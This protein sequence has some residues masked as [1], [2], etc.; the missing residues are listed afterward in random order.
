VTIVR[1]RLVHR[2][3]GRWARLESNDQ[4]RHILKRDPINLVFFCRPQSVSAADLN[5][6]RACRWRRPGG[7]ASCIF[8][9]GLR[10]REFDDQ[11][12]TVQASGLT[13]PLPP[14]RDAVR[15]DRTARVVAAAR[16][17][18]RD[19]D[20]RAHDC[21]DDNQTAAPHRHATDTTRAPTP[22]GTP[23]PSSATASH[24]AA[25]GTSNSTLEPTGWPA[26]LNVPTSN[27]PEPMRCTLA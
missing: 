13:P 27:S 16:A 18:R 10:R 22:S 1:R 8:A 26:A 11:L 24:A 4:P 6:R 21:A 23:S 5:E 20:Q 3:C 17:R 25:Y 19:T 7:T 15:H 9:V 12:V 2:D 14:G